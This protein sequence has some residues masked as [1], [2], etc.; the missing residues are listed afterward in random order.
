MTEHLNLSAVSHGYGDRLLLD[1]TNLV[2]TAG[3]HVAI[4]GENGAGKS[5]LL[6]LLAGLEAPDE[7]AAT[8]HGRVGY[9]AQTHG[10]PESITVGAAIDVSWPRCVRLRLSWTGWRQAW[11]TR[12]TR[13]WKPTDGSRPSTSCA[14][15]TR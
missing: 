7:G 11:P 10:L 1:G 13:S 5:T 9:L 12:R 4:V 14:K 8:N 15:A 3:E 2:I 6:R